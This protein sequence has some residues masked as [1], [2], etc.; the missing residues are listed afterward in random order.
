[1]QKNGA[2][3]DGVRR[4][5]NPSGRT[6]YYIISY[7]RA[8]VNG[9]ME[10]TCRKKSSLFVLLGESLQTDACICRNLLTTAGI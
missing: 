1:M 5:V 10:R 6:V 4:F 3:V 7:I 9:K 2:A 8:R